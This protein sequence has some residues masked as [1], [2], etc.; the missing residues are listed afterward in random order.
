MGEAMTHPEDYCHRCLGPLPSWHAPSPLWNAV[1][2]ADEQEPF[3]GIVCPSCFG[4]LARRRGVTDHLCVTTHDEKITLPTFF[5]D[6]RVWDRDKCM[7]VE[8][9]ATFK[10]GRS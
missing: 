5:G 1:M 7:W 2:R 3:N 10:G 9:G 8:V 4:E 6:G